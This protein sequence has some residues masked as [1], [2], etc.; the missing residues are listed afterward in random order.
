[1]KWKERLQEDIPKKWIEVLESLSKPPVDTINKRYIAHEHCS[2]TYGKYATDHPAFVF[3]FSLIPGLSVDR[4]VMNNTVDAV[5]DSWKIESLWGWDFPSLAM[6]CARL[7]RPEDAVEMLLLDSPKNTYRMNGHNAQIGNDSLPLY[8]PGN[9]A[10]L[11]AI[12]MMCAGWDGEER[13]TPGFP[14][15]GTWTVTHEGFSRYL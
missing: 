9:G 11:L 12:G 2:D 15:D 7:G 1:M 5:L 6:T 8:L 4:R 3:P 13:K 14:K 10:L